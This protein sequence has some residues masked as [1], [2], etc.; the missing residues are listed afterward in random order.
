[1]RDPPYARRL[2]EQALAAARDGGWQASDALVVVEEA[3][4]A[5]FSAPDG[6]EEIERRSY[7]DTELIILRYRK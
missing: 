5:K 3:V 1:M 7:D 4:D 6:F 2:A